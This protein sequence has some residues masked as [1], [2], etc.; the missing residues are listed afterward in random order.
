MRTKT[1]LLA[2]AALA[3]GI[4]S[5]VAQSNVYSVNIVGYVNKGLTTQATFISSPLDNG[6]NDLNSLLPGLAKNSTAS[7]WTG[8]A[9]T[10]ATKGA[11]VWTPNFAVSNGVGFFVTSKTILTNTFVGNVIVGPGGSVTNHLLAGISTAVASMIPYAGDLNTTNIGL[12]VLA[13]NSTASFWAG[14]YYTNS[15]KGATIWTPALPINV[16]DGFFLNSKTAV[17]WI[18]NLPA[19]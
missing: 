9:F 14:S 18:Q 2:V 1:L 15:T 3:A 16:A 5:S 8:S 7:F 17:D 12:G 6:T 4:A 19:N 11:T 10:N 13:K